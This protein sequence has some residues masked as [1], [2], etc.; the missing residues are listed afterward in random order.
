MT[1]EQF[2]YSDDDIVRSVREGYTRNFEILIDR[3]KKKIVNFIHKMISD[4]DEAQSLAQ[5]TFIK[6]YQ[7]IPKYQSMDN[8][9]SFIFTVAK[10]IT[11]NYI[12]K[13]KRIQF[14]SSFLSPAEENKHF[15][16]KDTQH[17]LMEKKQQEEIISTAIKN[18]NENQRLALILKVYLDFSYQKIEEITGWSIP[19]IET[20]ISRAKT[21]LKTQ[22]NIMTNSNPKEKMQEKPS[23]NVLK[24]RV[25]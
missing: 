10:N 7:S 6:V 9:Q 16:T 3:Y 22:V 17:A 4:Y 1:E 21:N 23:K 8:F 24:R 13:Q 20:L 5:D 2:E 18:L 12:K 25:A 14:F 11:L 15:Q 19:K